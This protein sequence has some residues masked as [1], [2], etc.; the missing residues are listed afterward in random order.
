MVCFENQSWTDAKL[1]SSSVVDLVLDQWHWPTWFTHKFQLLWYSYSSILL[2]TLMAKLERSNSHFGPRVYHNNNN[3]PGFQY[4]CLQYTD[5]RTIFLHTCKE[6]CAVL[7]ILYL[8]FTTEA[9]VMLVFEVL[10][11]V[12]N[13]NIRQERLPR[14]KL[15]LVS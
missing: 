13:N 10:L 5:K 3:E 4:T 14:L 9:L 1:N 15:A 2:S 7:P 12:I 8:P 11:M 6:V